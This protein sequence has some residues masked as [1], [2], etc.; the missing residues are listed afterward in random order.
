MG[1]AAEFLGFSNFQGLGLYFVLTYFI[2][3][4]HSYVGRSV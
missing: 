3:V 2:H 4:A 1:G